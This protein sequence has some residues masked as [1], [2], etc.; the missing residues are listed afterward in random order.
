[1][2]R[3]D[4][5]GEGGVWFPRRGGRACRSSSISALERRIEGQRGAESLSHLSEVVA[6]H[7]LELVVLH[8]RLDLGQPES[9]F[10][11]LHPVGHR[12]FVV[13]EDGVVRLR[14]DNPAPRQT[15][16]MAA[17]AA[18]ERL[19]V[20]VPGVGQDLQDVGPELPVR[21]SVPDFEIVTGCQAPGD[22]LRRGAGN[23]IVG[24]GEGAGVMSVQKQRSILS[25]QQS[26]SI[27]RFRDREPT[28]RANRHGERAESRPM[29]AGRSLE[30]FDFLLAPSRRRFEFPGLPPLDRVGKMRGVDGSSF[31]RLVGRDG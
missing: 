20:P 7:F 8:H 4:L 12:G 25:D 14:V 2:A 18:F 6:R 19:G 24:P 11:L 22:A 17:Q 26:T 10:Y 13:V 28:N 27:G 21:D 30:S 23:P 1:M 15:G 16:V 5:D 29:L 9:G 3:R 31:R